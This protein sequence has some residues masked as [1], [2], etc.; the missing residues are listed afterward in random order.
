MATEVKWE[1]Y[2]VCLSLIACLLNRAFVNNHIFTTIWVDQEQEVS[3]RNAD[4]RVN[5][6]VNAPNL[7][8][9][10]VILSIETNLG[11][12]VLNQGKIS[13]IYVTK[14]CLIKHISYKCVP[15]IC[16]SLKHLY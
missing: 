2:V 12:V 1:L 5:I 14:V 6:H 13:I 11:N 9:E 10:V 4:I 7:A 8:T 16:I 3:H 15:K